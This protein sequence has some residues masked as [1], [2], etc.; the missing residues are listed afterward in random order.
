MENIAVVGSAGSIGGAMVELLRQKYPKAQLS[1]MARACV[2]ATDPQITSYNIDL[3]D[4][5]SIEIASSQIDAPLDFVFVATGMLQNDKVRPEKS[6]RDLSAENFLR[7]FHVNTIGPALL[8]KH[9]L[10]KLSQNSRSVFATLS[11]RVGSIHDN[12]LGGWYGYRASKAA[13]NMVVKS[14]SIEMARKNK[15]AIIV[16][17]HPGTVDSPLSKPFQGNVPEGKL[18]SA[19][20]AAKKLLAVVENLKQNQTG[21]VYAWD[22][23]PIPY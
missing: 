5:E 4:E 7:L 3:L 1:L 21:G 8:A 16:G 14:A 18:F 19:D 10:P 6:L 13:L 20:Y 15:N 17:L 12:R 11:A 2:E 23:R 22:G 9:F